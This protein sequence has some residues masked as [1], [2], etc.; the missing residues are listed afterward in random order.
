[1][2]PESAWVT[3]GARSETGAGEVRAGAPWVGARSGSRGRRAGGGVAGN[4]TG[5]GA[6]GGEVWVVN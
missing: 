2:F 1:M 4:K 5:S 6:E 3:F